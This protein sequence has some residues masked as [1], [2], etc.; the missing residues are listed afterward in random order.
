MAKII[1]QTVI[2]KVSVH[3]VYEALMDEN[4][5]AQ[6]TNSEAKIGR[7]VGETFTAYDSYISGKNIEL[8]ADQ[9]IVQEWRAVDWQAGTTSLVTFEFNPVPEG[10]RLDF[11]HSGL[12]DGTEDG[13]AQ[14]WIDNYWDPMH[15]LFA[16]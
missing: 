14:G 13:F 9:K 8:I 6:F 3:E 10:T 16:G 11:T 12:P 15:R 1:E 4:I 5:H 2:F 7:A